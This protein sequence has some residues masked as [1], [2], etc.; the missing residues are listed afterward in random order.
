[1]SKIK[2][3]LKKEVKEY[4]DEKGL[5]MFIVAML[6]L[7]MSWVLIGVCLVVWYYRI[8]KP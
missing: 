4:I 5:L 6:T 3:F 2:K 8:F 1:M 7:V